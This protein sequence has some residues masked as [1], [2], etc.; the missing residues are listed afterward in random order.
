MQGR[1]L[2]EQPRFRLEVILHRGVE[3][4]VILGQ[5]SEPRDG[6]MSPQYTTQRNRVTGNLHDHVRHASLFHHGEKCLKVRGFGGGE[7]R[8]NLLPINPG[9]RG[10]DQPG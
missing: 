10:T 5:I 2:L 1:I 6:E 8:R 4:Q 3:I 7:S 9:T